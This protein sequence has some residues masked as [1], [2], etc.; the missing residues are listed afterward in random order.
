MLLDQMSQYTVFDHTLL[1]KL[2][3]FYGKTSRKTH[4]K[5][6]KKIFQKNYSLLLVQ[7]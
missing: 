3:L 6:L 1:Y 4:Q 7:N 5:S 2:D